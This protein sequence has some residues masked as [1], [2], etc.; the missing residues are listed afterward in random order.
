MLAGL[1]ART[2]PNARLNSDASFS[3]RDDEM[4][5]PRDL[6][7]PM[8]REFIVIRSFIWPAVWNSV[9]RRHMD[10][11]ASEKNVYFLRRLRPVPPAMRVK[12]ARRLIT[13]GILY[14]ALLALT[15][16]LALPGFSHANP[17]QFP[18]LVTYTFRGSLDL[19]AEW[20]PGQSFSGSISIDPK[21]PLHPHEGCCWA[22]YFPYTSFTFSVGDR[23]LSK[24]ADSGVCN[25]GVWRS[26]AGKTDIFDLSCRS[27]EDPKSG[28]GV[29][30]AW[31]RFE[32]YPTDTIRGW[33][34]PLGPIAPDE[35]QNGSILGFFRNHDG[36]FPFRG[37]LQLTAVNVA[38]EPDGFSIL[39][40][41][42]FGLSVIRESKKGTSK[43]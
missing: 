22:E 1:F 23:T 3:V 29:M 34:I 6:R 8:N 42:L 11:A 19:D 32:N 4:L 21:T 35:F 14:R 40:L 16:S 37:S 30:S 33:D 9:C 43:R 28:N 13:R 20:F 5:G 26:N 39:C 12:F 7:R 17:L 10:G 24:K 36:F 2:V 31:W 25:F 38:S 18:K 15:L 27:D 41:G